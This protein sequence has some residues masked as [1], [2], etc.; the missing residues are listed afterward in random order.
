MAK[1]KPVRVRGLVPRIDRADVDPTSTEAVLNVL[2]LA[3]VMLQ[4]LARIVRPVGLTPTGVDVLRVLATAEGP[5][6]P[7]SIAARLFVTTGTMSTV[8]D[9]LERR[10]FV[11]RSRHPVD[12]RKVLVHLH[13]EV[14]PLV[15]EILDR[16]HRLQRDLLAGL[17]AAERETLDE[18]LIRVLTAADDV[19][20]SPAHRPLPAPP[21]GQT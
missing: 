8:L 15:F 1:T 16:Y 10:G 9:T 4:A 2:R 19:I 13:P 18:L 3:D 14:K 12:R 11:E 5:M 21:D 6:T 7:V 20:A 17:S